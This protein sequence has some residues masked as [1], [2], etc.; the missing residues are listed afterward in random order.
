MVGT[1]TTEGMFFQPIPLAEVDPMGNLWFFT[2][3]DS[4]HAQVVR[5]DTRIEVTYSNEIEKVFVGLSGLALVGNENRQ[6]MKELFYPTLMNWLPDGLENPELALMK[7]R[8][9]EIN[10]WTETADKVW[11]SV[12]LLSAETGPVTNAWNR[13]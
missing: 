8:P 11:V 1:I 4:S 10:Q 12:K 5:E 9:T 2:H 3:M 6:R 7:I 13:R